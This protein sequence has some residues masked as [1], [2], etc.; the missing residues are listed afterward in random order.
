MNIP[1][2]LSSPGYP[3]FTWTVDRFSSATAQVKEARIWA[4]IHFR[5]SCNVGEAQ[6]LALADYILDNFLFPLN[7]AE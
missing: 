4:G 3:G 6:G 2:T 5:N 1:F 7:D